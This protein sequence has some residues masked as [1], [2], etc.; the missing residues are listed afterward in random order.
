MAD[1]TLGGHHESTEPIHLCIEGYLDVGVLGGESEECFA[2]QA[3]L[4]FA[5]TTVATQAAVRPERAGE[6]AG[7][8]LTSLVPLG[9]VGVGVSGTTFELLQGE[10]LS[11]G[12]AIDRVFLALAA[13]LLVAGLGVLAVRK[14]GARSI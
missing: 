7:V 3:C 10:G 9:G 2:D 5:F 8:A 11:I 6:A 1:E 12:A 14:A 13:G 4:V